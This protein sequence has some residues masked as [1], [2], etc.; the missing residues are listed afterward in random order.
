MIAAPRF[1]WRPP[2]PASRLLRP[3]S[4][5]YGAIAASRMRSASALI[6]PLPTICVGNPT[7]GG[8]GKTPTAM[9]IA[10]AATAL[11]LRPGFLTR[12][13]GRAT[14]G[15]LLVDPDRHDAR[16]VG[17]EPLLLAAVAPTVVAEDR[18]A[19]A[20]LLAENGCELIVMDDGFQSRQLAPDLALLVV[21]GGRGLGNGH[22]LPGGPLRAPLGVQLRHVDAVVVV[23]SGRGTEGADA[24][25]D[26]A[27]TRSVEVMRA[28]LVPEDG[29]R[30]A[31]RRVVAFS[32][33]GDPARFVAMLDALGADVVARRDFPDHHA[34][35]ER[36][37][38]A[39]GAL[40]REYEALPVTTSKDAARIPAGSLEHEVLRVA[41]RFEDGA[42]E[43]LVAEA[44]RHHAERT[45]AP[46]S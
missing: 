29:E 43:R 39:I 34:F 14:R 24:F 10:R 44:V 18:L 28:R 37:L 6:P 15:E 16:E 3:A 17:D 19:G 30:L 45:D 8:A 9:A 7:V 27:R 32:G 26:L 20:R 5:L 4:A 22:V 25:C 2:G 11:G 12:G 42:A 33:L 38:V 1:W 23:D 41:I 31:G 35:S 21:D 46:P 13:Y 36:D 40:A